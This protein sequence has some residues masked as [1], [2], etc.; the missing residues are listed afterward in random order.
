MYNYNRNGINTIQAGSFL[1]ALE[2]GTIFDMITDMNS[3]KI[4]SLRF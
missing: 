2:E 4:R 3:I 1:V